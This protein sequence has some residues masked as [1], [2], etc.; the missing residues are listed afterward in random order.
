MPRGVHARVSKIDWSDAVAKRAYI[1]AYR[2]E[3]RRAGIE[4]QHYGHIAYRRQEVKVEG[5]RD[6]FEVA[7][8]LNKALAAYDVSFW[9]HAKDDNPLVVNGKA[10]LAAYREYW[11][12]D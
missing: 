11:E 4:P 1:A 7:A 5:K 6:I 10:A 9:V 2:R 12:Q 8:Q 3:R